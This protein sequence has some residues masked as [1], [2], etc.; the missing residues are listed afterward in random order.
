MK[1]FVMAMVLSLAF[2]VQVRAGAL[3]VTETTYDSSK[4]A[5]S[6]LSVGDKSIRVDIEG[7]KGNNTVIY[8]SDKQTFWMVNDKDKSY[9]EMTKAQMD[10]MAQKMSDAMKN[11][12]PAVQK[13][14]AGKMGGAVELPKYVKKASGE[15]VGKWTATR[16]EAVTKKG[17][18]KM[19][20]VP[21]GTI[22]ITP[23]D[24]AV[25]KEFAKFFEKFGKNQSDF[26]KFDRNDM[27][28]TGVPVKSVMM[29]GEKVKSTSELKEAESKSFPDSTFD[30]PAGYKKKEMKGI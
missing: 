4:V 28:F 2:T 6:I 21:A 29:E 20:T 1:R 8:R 16:Y 7:E 30:V 25:L 9:T 23:S 17:V 5:K 14:M 19:W 13:M 10:A 12:P 18:R 24:V 15:K 3:M 27:G 26:F 22:G 11:M